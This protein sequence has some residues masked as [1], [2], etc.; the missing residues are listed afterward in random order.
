MIEFISYLFIAFGILQIILFFKVWGM[1]NN[2]KKL[3]QGEATN[4]TKAEQCFI[5][6][7]LN[8]VEKYLKLEVEKD[9]N[10]YKRS[11]FHFEGKQTKLRLSKIKDL[12][13]FYG[14]NIPSELA[15]VLKD[16]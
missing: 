9:I 4:L 10:E 8:G 13:I 12:Y 1:T 15:E 7:N 5:C 14:I 3:T 6:N 16:K 11:E 2:V